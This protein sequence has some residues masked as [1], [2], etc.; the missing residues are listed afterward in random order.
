MIR[1]VFCMAVALWAV[2]WAW[3]ASA[4][5]HPPCW[6]AGESATHPLFHNDVRNLPKSFDDDGKLRIAFIWDYRRSRHDPSGMVAGLQEAID[7]VGVDIQVEVACSSVWTHLPLTSTSAYYY[8]RDK[9]AQDLGER[10]RADLVAVLSV[11]TGDGYCGVAS[12]GRKDRAFI[13]TSATS[14]GLDTFIHEVGHNFGIHHAH[15]EG[16]GGR[17]GWCMSPAD[18]SRNCLRGT[19]MSYASGSSRERRFADVDAGWGTEEHT[20]AEYLRES[21]P[22]QA[23]AWEIRYGF[24]GPDPEDLA[25]SV[26]C[27]GSSPEDWEWPSLPARRSRPAPTTPAHSH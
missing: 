1:E 8:V 16:Y 27:P 23:Q 10:N 18:G 22:M 17:K 5:D 19:V 14:C 4:G 25:G 9:Y 24:V 13:R 26:I 6:Q 12:L 15:Q 11:G 2:M 20:A 21:I 3:D 7:L